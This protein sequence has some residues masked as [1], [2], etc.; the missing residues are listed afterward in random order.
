M[1]ELIDRRYEVL[2]ALGSGG[3]AD[4]YLAHDEVLDR[5][6]ALKVLNR[7]FSGDA[8]FVERFRREARSAATLSHP[9]VV[10]IYDRGEAEDGACYISMEYLPGG[11]LKE[12]ILRDSPMDPRAVA[13]V[14][15]QIAEALE[16]AHEGGVIHRD[17]KPQNVLV[18]RAGDV[19]VGDFG[20]ARAESSGT[21][22]GNEILGTAAYMSPEQAAGR[23][24]DPRSD[25]YS[26]GVVMYE[27][28]TGEPPFAAD[29]SVSAAMKHANETPVPPRD[30]N[31]D[32]PG[33]INEI[34]VR[35]LSKDPDDRPP[36]A[37]ALADE[38]R[39]LARGQAPKNP[40]SPPKPEE[41]SSVR[42]EGTSPTSVYP[43]GRG[44]EKRTRPPARRKNPADLVP[45]LLVVFFIVGVV[46]GG[47]LVL[48][49]LGAPL[50]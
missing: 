28:L 19:K 20:I 5:D 46:A 14:A 35:L 8:E 27:M 11:T 23:P 21:M 29:G 2:E 49:V 7:R 43:E 33:A 36:G 12:R 13:E 39:S 26:L 17:V 41:A 9:N 45:W 40:K 16:A 47:I 50:P 10:P 6:V 48:R 15:A 31:P 30:K 42:P 18:T 37:G 3:M 38:L 1:G 22:T 4:V 25:L 34:V 32:V 24:V 44:R